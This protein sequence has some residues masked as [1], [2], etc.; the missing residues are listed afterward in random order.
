ME[1]LKEKIKAIAP[2]A[3]FEENTQVLTVDVDKNELRQLA[4]NL[5]NDES[6]AF[7]YL[8]D[9]IGLDLG[10]A[11]GTNYRLFSTKN[12]N[13]ALVV[14]TKTE[15]RENPALQSV[16]DL[17]QSANLYEREVYDFLGIKFIGHPDLRRLFLRPDW[18]GYPL[19]KDYDIESNP[20][21][22]K[23]ESVEE[24]EGSEKL[25]LDSN[26]HI[27]ESNF[28][29]FNDKDY[30]VSFGPQHPSTHGV[31][32]LRVSLNGET[33]KHIDPNFGYIHRGIEKMCESYTY[34]KI[35][36]L[37]ERLDYLSAAINRHGFCLCVEKALELE[38]PERAVYVRTIFDELTRIASHLLGW[39]SMANDMGAITAFIYGMRDREKI[40]DIFEE[41]AGGRLFTN[42]SVIGGM[43]QDIHPNFQKRVKEFIPYM[44]KMLKEY[45]TLFTNNPIAKQRM[46]SAGWLKI[47]DA[48]SY[49]V[50]GPSG[51]ASNWH[52]D[53]RKIEPYA[54][55]NKV[56]FNEITRENGGSFDRYM[57]RLDEILE[58]LSII[59]QL[60]DN[61][62]DGDYKAKT[63]P[64][65]KLPEGEFYQRV[66][67]ARG[68][69][70]I[71]IN[72][73]GDKTP[74]RVKFRSPSETLVSALEP[75]VK[76]EKIADLIMIGGSLD[77]VIPCIDR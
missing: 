8:Q 21:T 43:M 77:Y 3:V 23:N 76:G 57:V 61:I 31:L 51:R 25:E 58:S 60:I 33:V 30:V 46:L 72:S 1:N 69:F 28:Q 63:K 71:Y 13:Q 47:E 73:K 75:T 22:L 11:L 45:H 29:L 65:I 38:V 32:Q 64:I 50:T 67:N 74:Y 12:N 49:G 68:D 26:G 18:K 53:I 44:R 41:T 15:D 19:R 7:D 40:M 62:P 39:A 37:C 35:L 4:E 24:F 17:W 2:S 66:E 6:L 9:I 56:N 48:I 27:K 16:S 34:P 36:H 59:E 54:A 14:K 10:D 20:I 42:Y 52:N 5:K 55:Y 70:N